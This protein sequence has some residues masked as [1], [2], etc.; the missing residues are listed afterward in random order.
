VQNLAAAARESRTAIS[1][2]YFVEEARKYVPEITRFDVHRGP[3]GIRAQA[4]NGD[5]SLEDD[6]VISGRDRL[7][8]LRNAPSPGATSS[9][10]IAEYIVGEALDR[11]NLK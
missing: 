5:G 3:R 8:H 2:R 11:A 9:L 10:A 6:F 7:I 4:M 1:T